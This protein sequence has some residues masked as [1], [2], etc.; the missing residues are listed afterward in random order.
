MV[1]Y[2]LLASLLNID[3]GDRKVFKDKKEEKKDGVEVV[4]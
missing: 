1:N 2:L 4:N 3:K